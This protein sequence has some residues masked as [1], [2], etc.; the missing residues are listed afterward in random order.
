MCPTK[1]KLW[2]LIGSARV[3]TK[4]DTSA[5]AERKRMGLQEPGLLVASTFEEKEG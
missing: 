3:S 5:E 1:P 4:S 2:I